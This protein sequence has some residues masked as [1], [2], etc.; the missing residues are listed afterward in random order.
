MEELG[1]VSSVTRAIKPHSFIIT[2]QENHVID[3]ETQRKQTLPYYSPSISNLK[4]TP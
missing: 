4:P 3:K 2:E 1:A